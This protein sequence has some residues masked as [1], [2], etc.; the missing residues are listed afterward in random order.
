MIGAPAFPITA[1]FPFLG[2]LG[3]LPLPVKYHIHFGEPLR[4]EGHR[5]DED[6]VIQHQVDRVKDQISLLI[7][8]GLEERHGW[9]R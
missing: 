5:S 2:P 9:F 7:E 1:T 3:Y 4:L 8:D 6:D